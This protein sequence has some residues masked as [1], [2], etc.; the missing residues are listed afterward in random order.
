M[1]RIVVMA[2]VAAAIVLPGCMEVEQ[3][4]TGSRQ[5]KYQGKPDGKPWENTPLAYES[6]KWGKGDR[7]SWEEQIKK[8]QF[9]QHEDRR[10]YQ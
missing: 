4:S 5:G 7:N 1:K 3:A 8:R 9:T 6:Q 10:I 2:A